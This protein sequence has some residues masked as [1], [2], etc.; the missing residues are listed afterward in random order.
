MLGKN[1]YHHIEIFV[2]VKISEQNQDEW[3][4]VEEVARHE[5]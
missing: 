2:V 5:L 1:M 4:D 3:R